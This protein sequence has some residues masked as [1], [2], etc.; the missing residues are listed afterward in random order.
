MSAPAARAKTAGMAG[1]GAGSFVGCVPMCRVR[2]RAA[3][4]GFS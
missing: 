4:Y 3:R 1:R 2:Q